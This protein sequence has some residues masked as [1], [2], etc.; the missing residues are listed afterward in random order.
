MK[1]CTIG[2]T[3]EERRKASR[4]RIHENVYKGV[5]DQLQRGDMTAECVLSRSHLP[6]E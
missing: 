4:N 2:I 3:E 5:T 1:I 6:N